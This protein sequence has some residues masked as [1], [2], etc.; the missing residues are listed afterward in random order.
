M[1]DHESDADTRQPKSI[2]TKKTK[3]VDAK[4]V[5]SKTKKLVERQPSDD[6]MEEREPSSPP[7]SPA[8]KKKSSSSSRDAA[9]K[10]QHESD[11]EDA[12][13]EEQKS[14]LIDEM[15]GDD[16]EADMVAALE[17]QEK[18]QAKKETKKSQNPPPKKQRTEL[19]LPERSDD[20]E[21][22]A[23][24]DA[25]PPSYDAFA[26]KKKPVQGPY[27]KT[28][29]KRKHGE[30]DEDEEE[31][32]SD[33]DEAEH[34]KND[35]GSDSDTSAPAAASASAKK[36]PFES[37]PVDPCYTTRKW[38]QKNGLHAHFSELT[39][40]D[41]MSVLP[42]PNA[43]YKKAFFSIKC[44]KPQKFDFAAG[45]NFKQHKFGNE[46]IVIGPFASTSHPRMWPYGDRF[47]LP[48]SQFGPPAT[49]SKI[50][51]KLPLFNT[52]FANPLNQEKKGVGIIDPT[53]DHFLQ[54]WC[55]VVRSS[56]Y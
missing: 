7:P 51:L 19:P 9:P 52:G 28:V 11:A 14:S 48:H 42:A 20:D 56:T 53:A 37:N 34:D 22:N 24:E 13:D 17:K 30:S 25:P 50:K 49:S 35:S 12:A 39:P 6:E 10:A 45:T 23:N 44:N 47:P 46:T 33:G 16:D 3:Y 15:F 38:S 36:F 29:K 31:D 40:K 8:K 21:E 18:K 2:K 27:A 1:S 32:A 55:W 26:K 43:G 54:N 41:N 4:D 5:K